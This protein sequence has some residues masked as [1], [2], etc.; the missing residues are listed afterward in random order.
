MNKRNKISLLFLI[1]TWIANPAFTQ[2]KE[3]VNSI[4]E[5]KTAKVTLNVGADLVS[6]YI[7]RGQNY[8]NSPAIQ[9]TLSLDAFGFTLGAW[10]SYGLSRSTFW[11]DDS[12]SVEENYSEIDLFVAYTYKYF[13]LMLTDYY[14]AIPVDTLPG[15]N[16]FNWKN[17]TTWHTM[18]LTLI[19]DGPEKFP[20]QFIA[21]TL[22]YGAD[23]GKDT[24][25]VYGY[26][27]GNNYSTYFELAYQF[28]I[29][30]FGIK[31]FIGGIPFG[32][33]WYGPRAGINNIG[34]NVRKEIPLSKK[35]S[36]PVQSNLVFNPLSKKAYLVFI[37][38]L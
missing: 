22:I 5:E 14:V 37:L 26:G 18:E 12:T 6:R 2:E 17:T 28:N 4:E 3:E 31:P 9:P 10:G 8:G 21:S 33:S 34:I 20:I 36:L 7:W 29:K 25:G 13:T 27:A 16:Y 15:M 11:I 35:F 23:K 38:T 1:I 32:S 24:N 30:G 19:L